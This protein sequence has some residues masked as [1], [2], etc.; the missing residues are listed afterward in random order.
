[1]LENEDHHQHELIRSMDGFEEY[2]EWRVTEEKRLQSAFFVNE[3]GE[4]IVDFVG[5]L[6]TIQEDFGHV[7]GEIGVNAALPHKNTSSHRDYR[8]YYTEHTRSLVREHFREDIRRFGYTF[9]GSYP[10]RKEA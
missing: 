5:H 8:N 7:C 6:E 9:G 4:E 2:I 1:M 10:A 3:D